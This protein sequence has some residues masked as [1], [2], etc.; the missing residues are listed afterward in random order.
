MR[1]FTS[2]AS[3]HF[4]GTPLFEA[5]A[6]LGL[7]LGA[8]VFTAA[9]WVSVGALVIEPSA[10]TVAANAPGTQHVTLPTVVIVGQR[11]SMEFTPVTTTAQNTA[12]IPVTLR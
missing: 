8:A 2:T 9:I 7:T 12:A 4:T 6:E 3:G 1:R 5:L 11:D 10:S